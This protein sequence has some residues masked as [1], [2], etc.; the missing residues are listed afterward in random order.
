MLRRTLP[1][2][3]AC[4]RSSSSVAWWW[5]GRARCRGRSG[6][7]GGRLGRQ[8]VGLVAQSVDVAAGRRRARTAPCRPRCRPRVSAGTW[9]AFEVGRLHQHG[10]DPQHAARAALVDGDTVALEPDEVGGAPV[11]LDGGDGAA[12]SASRS[13]ENSSDPPREPAALA[14][15]RAGRL[16]PAAGPGGRSA[17]S[18]SGWRVATPTAALRVLGAPSR[19]AGSARARV[20]GCCADRGQ[21]RRT[22]RRRARR[23]RRRRPRR[24]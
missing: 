21:R 9:Y 17:A 4:A 6:R 7:G 12:D 3:R 16:G 24:P 13:S 15:S 23:R 1:I 11:P 14:G 5:S 18:P 10:I 19:P 8:L 20:A 2:M 22:P